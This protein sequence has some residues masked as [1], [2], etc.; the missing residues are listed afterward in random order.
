MV[1]FDLLCELDEAQRSASIMVGD[2]VGD[3]TAA[4]DNG[5]DSLAVG[6]GQESIEQLTASDPTYIVH[7]PEAMSDFLQTHCP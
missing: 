2:R 3:I 6:F 7:T 4:A 1:I 5:I